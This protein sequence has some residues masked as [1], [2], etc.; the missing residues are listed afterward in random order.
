MRRSC[1]TC[2]SRPTVPGA[3]AR[4]LIAL[5][6]NCNTWAL[7]LRHSKDPLLLVYGLA[8][9]ATLTVDDIQHSEGVQALL[10]VHGVRLGQER[11]TDMSS[12]MISADPPTS[13]SL[14]HQATRGLGKREK[15]SVA[16]F[17]SP[18]FRTCKAGSS[19]RRLR[20][21]MMQ[22]LPCMPR[23]EMPDGR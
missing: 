17:L 6:C 11:C 18:C 3:S 21:S 19:G 7:P 9:A 10:M 1:N 2:Y 4:A 12:A 8:G 15:V 22:L 13:P 23:F 5:S 20:L 16:R 14:V